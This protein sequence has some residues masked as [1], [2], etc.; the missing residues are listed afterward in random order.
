MS[1]ISSTTNQL[2]F[3]GVSGRKWG[4]WQAENGVSGILGIGFTTGGNGTAFTAFNNSTDD[5]SSGIIFTCTTDT[6]IGHYCQVYTQLIFAGKFNPR[7]KARIRNNSGRTTNVRMF[8]GLSNQTFANNPAVQNGLSSTE[9]GI[10]IGFSETDTNYVVCY[11]DGSAAQIRFDTGIPKD[12]GVWHDIEIGTNDGGITWSWSDYSNVS[13]VSGITYKTISSR[14][15]ST[16][17]FMRFIIG[18]VVT[19]TT[20]AATTDLVYAE[21]EVSA[22]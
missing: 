13:G 8:T 2:G 18:A 12:N 9:S 19:E 15:P 3:P 20:V 16:T 6:T 4:V 10:V 1:I 5:G 17:T 7:V 22:M 21:A 14:L 11:N